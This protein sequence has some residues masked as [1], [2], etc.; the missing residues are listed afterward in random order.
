MPTFVGV[1]NS[2]FDPVAYARLTQDNLGP[3]EIS[4]ADIL[5]GW[6]NIRDDLLSE[7][8]VE[9]VKKSPMFVSTRSGK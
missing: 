5:D 7:D 4:T 1:E 2:D 9:S 8:F 6:R 3:Q